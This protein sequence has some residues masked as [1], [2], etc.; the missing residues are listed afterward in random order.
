MRIWS[1]HPRYLDAK[2][3]VAL[4]RE[5]LLAKN[6]LLGNTK[7]YKNHPQLDRFKEYSET[8]PAINKYLEIVYE[9]SLARGYHFDVTKFEASARSYQ[10]PV[11]QGQVD[12]EMQHL[13]SKLKVRDPNRY[14]QVLQEKRVEVHPLFTVVEGDIEPWEHI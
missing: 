4:W 1:I 12:Y 2:G 9:E 3:I 11:T 6:V 13:L 8:V 10:I 7:G 14:E 5:T